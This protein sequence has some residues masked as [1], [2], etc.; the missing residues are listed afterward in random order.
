MKKLGHIQEAVLRCLNSHYGYWKRDDMRCGWV[1][2]TQSGTERILKSMIPHGVVR[3][4]P[5]TK[6]YFPVKCE[7]PMCNDSAS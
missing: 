6:K 1:W 3:Y 5:V 7:V 2:D 4:D